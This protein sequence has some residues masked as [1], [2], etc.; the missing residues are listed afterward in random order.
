MQVKLKTIAILAENAALSSI[1][2]MVLAHHCELRVREFENEMDIVLYMR[3]AGIDLLIYDCA[4]I[5]SETIAS[6]KNLRSLAKT[7]GHE[8]QTIALCKDVT[9]GS[10]SA[11][12]R[13][14]IDEL[15]IKPMSPIYLEERVLARVAEGTTA[16]IFD[17]AE[18]RKMQPLALKP[19]EGRTHV[20]NYGANVIPLFGRDRE[21]LPSRHPE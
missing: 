5:D 10:R 7:S 11:C 9:D 2:R 3:I 17:G 6:I 18:R 12:E 21:P 8:F 16:N 1:L 15:I 13:A 14:G 19:T 4:Q 20:A